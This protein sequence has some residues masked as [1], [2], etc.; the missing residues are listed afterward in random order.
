MS[1][2]IIV[3]LVLGIIFLLLVVGII[4]YIKSKVEDFSQAAFGT[5]S[6]KSGLRNVEMEYASTP[7]TISGMTS[8]Y[9]P[10]ITR[11]FPSFN[12]DEMRERAEHLLVGYLM[13]ID[14]D[15][16]QLTETA[17]SDLIHQLEQH[18]Q[19]LSN[20]RQKEHFKNIKTHQSAI[21][22]YS[23]SEG[24]CKV[25]FQ[26]SVQHYHYI[27]SEDNESE[28]ISGKDNILEQARYEVDMIYIQD[29]EVVEKQGANFHSLNCPN[30]GA[31]I[32]NLGQKF[33]DF[34]GTG[35]VE[36][37]I[38]VWTFSDVREV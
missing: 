3:M 18:L 32:K 11:D 21:T 26:T 37:N 20:N 28:I 5:S 1:M 6:I 29:R 2:I 34:C 17:N 9:L 30:C 24:I 10:N 13:S 31:A 16:V 22:R 7:K 25:T 14:I 12:Y 19:I 33:C 4:F 35:I 38:D 36:F 27:V 23:K 15:K 8:L